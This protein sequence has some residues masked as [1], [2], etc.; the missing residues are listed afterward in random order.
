MVKPHE[1]HP[2]QSYKRYI[3]E[4]IE[5]FFN[6]IPLHSHYITLQNIPLYILFRSCPAPSVET[7]LIGAAQKL[8]DQLKLELKDDQPQNILQR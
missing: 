2:L 1:F 5:I 3:F 6:F 8:A 4:I 7:S